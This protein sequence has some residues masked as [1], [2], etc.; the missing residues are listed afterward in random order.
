LIIFKHQIKE[1]MNLYARFRLLLL[2]VMMGGPALMA[3]E[4]APRKLRLGVLLGPN[5]CSRAKPAKLTYLKIYP[6]LGYDLQ[7][8]AVKPVSDRLSLQAALG[9]S[10][11]V[12]KIDEIDF[13]SSSL[14]NNRHT[15]ATF[16]EQAFM[17]SAWA[18]Y[19]LSRQHETIFGTIGPELEKL[20]Q[21]KSAYTT[22]E[23]STI[24]SKGY[25]T[26]QQYRLALTLQASVGNRFLLGPS[27][28]CT[29]EA[30]FKYHN[31]NRFEYFWYPW[32]RLST[33]IRLGFWL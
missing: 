6:K 25:Y 20:I 17:L 8:T 12:Y 3:Q 1:K 10:R 5:L 13:T 24:I 30:Y 22:Y 26:A 9:T 31:F 2:L 14:P 28:S 7:L 19:S 27:L 4:S 11:L 16:R 33:G 18:R 32:H 29:V 23:N 15:E 21:G